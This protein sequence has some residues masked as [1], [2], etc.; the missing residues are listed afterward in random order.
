MLRTYSVS[1]LVA[2]INW[3][4][5]FHAWGIPSRYAGIAKIHACD[6][7][8]RQWTDSFAAEERQKATE[9]L[10]LYNDALRELSRM[11]GHVSIRCV[12]ELYPAVASGDDI[13]IMKTEDCKPFVL[14]MLRQQTPSSDGICL[15]LADFIH[16]ETSEK[17]DTIGIFA[18]SVSQT[19]PQVS[20][21]SSIRPAPASKLSPDDYHALMMQTLSDRLAEAGAERLHEYVRK[22]LWGYAPDEKLSIDELHAERY[23]GI[24][25][26]V[27]YPCLPDISVNFLLSHL[28]DFDSAGIRLTEHGMM[29]PHASVSGFMLSSP[30]ARYFAIGTVLDDQLADYAIRRGMPVEEIRKYIK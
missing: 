26:A 18:T 1:D 29:I 12:V 13:L 2:Y 20:A 8:R 11:N 9:A 3:P 15:S 28:I 10:S 23:Q 21:S 5:F 30:H 24:R 4:Y 22:E 27:G 6:A 16:D 14:P 7:C 19:A 17:T 25:P